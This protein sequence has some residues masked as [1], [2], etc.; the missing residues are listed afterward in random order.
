M[1]TTCGSA[2]KREFLLRTFPALPSENVGDS[3]SCSFESMVMK[4]TQGKGV[5]LV[6]NSLADDKLQ[7]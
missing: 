1:F 4:A 7:V 5:Q 2:G 6:L 3:R